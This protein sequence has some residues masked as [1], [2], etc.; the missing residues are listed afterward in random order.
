VQ[1]G[2]AGIRRPSS[3]WL[4]P[5]L[6]ISYGDVADGSPQQ[7]DKADKALA[8]A[9]TAETQMQNHA[10]ASFELELPAGWAFHA[11]QPTSSGGD[12]R[13]FLTIIAA[14]D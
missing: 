1:L 6:P 4:F 13:P 3:G 12:S 10:A 7:A 14:I 5:S 9:R 8:A 2:S 11:Q